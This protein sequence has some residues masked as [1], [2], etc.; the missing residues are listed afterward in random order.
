MTSLDQADRP[1]A[2]PPTIGGSRQVDIVV[3]KDRASRLYPGVN[4]QNLGLWET[5]I[6]GAHVV[7]G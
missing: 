2:V 7:P 6:R 5:P 4:R 3:T 1:M